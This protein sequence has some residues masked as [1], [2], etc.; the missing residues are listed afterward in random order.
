MIG[1]R[2]KARKRSGDDLGV[3]HPHAQDHGTVTRKVGGGGGHPDPQT[4][5]ESPGRATNLETRGGPEAGPGLNQEDR[6]RGR[7]LGRGHRVNTR[8]NVTKT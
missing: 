6:T 4:M 2:K 1:K 7:D 8:R 3:S 5:I